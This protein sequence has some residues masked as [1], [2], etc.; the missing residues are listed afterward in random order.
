[1][2]AGGIY[3]HLPY[4][5]SR[6]GYCAFVVTTDGSSRDAYLH[7]VEAEGALAVEEACDL[8]LIHI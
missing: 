8:S 2:T 7:A 3:V 1:M 4:C 5:A 6:C